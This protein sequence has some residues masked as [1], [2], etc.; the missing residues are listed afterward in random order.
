[1]SVL[2]IRRAHHS[3]RDRARNYRVL[4]DGR[5]R[6]E[7]GDDET[8]Q[9]PVTPGQHVVL[10]KIDWCRSRDLQ[11][12]IRHGEI[13]RLECKPHPLPF[14]VLLYITIWRDKYISLDTVTS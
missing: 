7:L 10:L 13:V 1:L 14:L 11:V 8:I 4:V 12:D 6:A 9:I 5:Q 3:W 2:V